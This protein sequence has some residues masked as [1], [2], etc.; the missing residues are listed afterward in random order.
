[1]TIKVKDLMSENPVIVGSNMSLK[2]AAQKMRSLNVG[3]LLVGTKKELKGVI[4]DRDIVVRAVAKGEDLREAKVASYM[5]PHYYSCNEEDTAEAVAEKF[6]QHK[7]LRL[8]VRNRIGHVT[9]ILSLGN[10]LKNDASA[11]DVCNMVK[12]AYWHD[13]YEGDT[14]DKMFA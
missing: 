2:S 9:G 11:C 8:I 6:H 5:T 4:T 14:C 13:F 1:M 7:V 12:N 3:L 10:L